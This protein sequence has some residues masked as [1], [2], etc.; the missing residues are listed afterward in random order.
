MRGTVDSVL[1]NN[2]TQPL[3]SPFAC[4]KHS[5]PECYLRLQVTLLNSCIMNKVNVLFSFLKK[6]NAA[7]KVLFAGIRDGL[8]GGGWWIV[9]HQELGS[10]Q[11]LFQTNSCVLNFLSP[12]FVGFVSD[13]GSGMNPFE[14]WGRIFLSTTPPPPPPSQRHEGVLAFPRSVNLWA[15]NRIRRNVYAWQWKL[16][17]RLTVKIVP[18]WRTLFP[19]AKRAQDGL[20]FKRSTVSDNGNA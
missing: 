5:F 2:V 6:K 4:W 17:F 8:E 16:P 1:Y 14:R 13:N 3:S 7:R 11:H 12:V 19:S 10:W 18:I 20:C 15:F 9:Q